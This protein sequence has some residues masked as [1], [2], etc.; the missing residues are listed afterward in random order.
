MF[1]GCEIMLN[2][3]KA[4]RLLPEDYR[5]ALPRC[6]TDDMEEIRLRLGRAPT[7]LSCGRERAFTERP[8]KEEDLSR[9]LEVAT[10]ASLHAAAAALADGYLSYRGLRIG[11][12]G[13]AVLREN[14]VCG[15]RNLSSAAIRIPAEHRGMLDWEAREIYRCPARSTLI[16]SPPGGGKTTALRELIR[17]LSEL[18]LRVGVVD[19]RN[20]LAAMDGARAQFDLGPRSDVLTGVMKSEGAM[21][22][23]RGMNPQMI[24]MDEISQERDLQAIEQ[25]VGCG[26]A[27]L[28]SA[29]AAG[30][31]ELAQR[32]LYRRLLDRQ[33]FSLFI[34]ISGVGAQRRYT[35][36][37]ASN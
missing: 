9:L 1:S 16:L 34:T 32:E 11:L 31:E 20:E 4:L 21:M 25:I 28:A 2:L 36:T 5:Q 17:K 35:L 24:A 30:P 18:G 26:V 10:E 7:L 12:C 37:R 27:L 13:T 19:E 3:E 15:F 29:H 22:L 14:K 6:N 8:V 23:L 33:V